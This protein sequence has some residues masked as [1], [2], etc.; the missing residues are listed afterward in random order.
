MFLKMSLG[1][2]RYRTRLTTEWPFKV[3]DVDVETELAWLG[4]DFITDDTNA[5]PIIRHAARDVK[6][7]IQ[8]VRRGSAYIMSQM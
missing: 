1:A 3:M 6:Q 5:T 2:E 7:N 4:E 8:F